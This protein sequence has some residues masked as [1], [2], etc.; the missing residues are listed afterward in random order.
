MQRTI[1][2]IGGTFLAGVLAMPAGCART[3]V[4]APIETSYDR[5]DI[6]SSVDFW[7]ELTSR[8]AVTNNEGLHGLILFADDDDPNE[9]YE[10]RVEYLT[11]LGWLPE[12]FDEPGDLAMQRG[13]LAKALS[14]ALE[15]E[16]GV[17]MGLTGKSPRYATREL[18]FLGIMPQ[19]TEQQVLSG[20]QYVGVISE[21]QDYELLNA[22][23]NVRRTPP[24]A[25]ELDARDA[26]EPSDENG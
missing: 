17:M 21:A 4:D 14:H 1:A 19:G 5:S 24:A 23:E 9:T 10:Q 13:T 7:H 6:V 15:I 25:S 22:G 11:A 20:Y 26:D 3:T 8:S 12:G 18:V 2:C 16:G